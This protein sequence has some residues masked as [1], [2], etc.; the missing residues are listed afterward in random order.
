VQTGVEQLERMAAV[1]TGMQATYCV[2]RR[3]GCVHVEEAEHGM[4]GKEAYW[5]A[6]AS[7]R[8]PAGCAPAGRARAR[9][10]ARAPVAVAVVARAVAARSLDPPVAV[11]E[12]DKIPFASI[13]T[14]DLA[15]SVQHK[16]K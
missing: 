7:G 1:C 8:A 9:A 13:P 10:R 11:V 14:T 6:S 3:P 2:S 15:A 4:N 12:T 16:A 5:T